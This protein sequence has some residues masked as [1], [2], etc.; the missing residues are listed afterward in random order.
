MDGWVLT[1]IF[2][3]DGRRICDLLVGPTDGRGN[4][5]AC[6]AVVLVIHD[7]LA[8]EIKLVAS[9][10]RLMLGVKFVM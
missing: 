2:R 10:H 8:G 1:L 6:D 5:F 4:C 7:W 9:S 3:M